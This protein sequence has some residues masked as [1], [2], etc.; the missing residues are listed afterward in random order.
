M[1][2]A[3]GIE[4]AAKVDREI[5]FKYHN[6]MSLTPKYMTLKPGCQYCKSSPVP[7]VKYQRIKFKAG[8]G[9]YLGRFPK[10]GVEFHLTMSKMPINIRRMLPKM[11]VGKKKIARRVMFLESSK[12]K[13]E[14]T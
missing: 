14:K 7:A 11:P 3:A 5:F 13:E 1:V 4:P 10:C 9:Y 6:F 12:K 8:V 2:E